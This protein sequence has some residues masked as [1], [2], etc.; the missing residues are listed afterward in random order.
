MRTIPADQITV[1][2]AANKIVFPGPNIDGYVL[3][4]TPEQTYAAGRQVD[5]PMLLSSVGTDG[6]SHNAVTDATNLAD[7]RKGAE[8]LYGADAPAFF[9]LFPASNDT[10]ALHQAKEVAR[11]TGYGIIERDWARA[12]SRA[13]KSPIWLVQ[14]N[15]PHPYPPGVVITDMDVKTAG[16]YHNSDL[17]FWFGTLDSL[18]LFRHTRDWTPYDY[19][20]SNQ[21]QDVIVGFARTGNPATAE[22]KIPR[23]DPRHEQR[24]LFGDAGLTVETLNEKQ[25]NFIENHP[26]KN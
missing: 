21:M 16:V 18:N 5:V 20:L 24:L 15:H 9:N 1:T 17:P 26:I 7:Y 6:N 22:A 8:K 3:P 10:E 23:Y 2:A 25:V 14:F 4:E 12:Q 13:A 11:I 19:K